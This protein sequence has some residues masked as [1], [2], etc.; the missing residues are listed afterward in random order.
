MAENPFD[1]R[2]AIE[3]VQALHKVSGLGCTVYMLRGS[4][5]V[6]VTYSEGACRSMCHRARDSETEFWC[7]SCQA[8]HNLAATLSNSFGGRYF[9]LCNEDRIFV[10]API[11]STEGLVAAVN[12]GPVHIFDI[13]E[14]VRHRGA[15]RPFPV[16]APAYVHYLSVLLS[17]AVVSVSEAS[18][19]ALL[20][21]QQ[22]EGTQQADIHRYI[23]MAR[24]RRDAEYPIEL[25]HNLIASI[26]RGDFTAARDELN[27]IIGFLLSSPLIGRGYTLHR[28]AYE[29][30]AVITRSGIEAGLESSVMFVTSE[31]YT[32][33]IAQAVGNARISKLL[34]D[35]LS[36]VVSMT[37]ELGSDSYD[38]ASFRAIE[39][40]R[41]H[42]ASKITLE[43]VARVVGFSP[44]YFSKNFKRRFGCTFSTYL[45]QVRVRAG[46]SL[47]LTTTSSIAAIAEAVGF[48]DASYFTRV[49]KKMTG[50]T[51]GYYRSHRGRVVRERER[52][53]SS[54][55]RSEG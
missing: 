29:L 45:N 10:A 33:K 34:L 37:S 12:L 25:E 1:E 18:Q 35:L 16:R 21:S 2:Q 14:N 49:F 48:D 47:L 6:E 44:S 15:L 30:C 36:E 39:Y 5:G 42:Y 11:V 9:Y 38:D 40:I 23:A 41:T 51:P 13:E 52:L 24:E 43:E 7:G 53:A 17:M 26:R 55:A 8:T 22:A 46:K 28:R 19:S 4:S 54:D 3:L 20:I 50:V 31:R 32:A 27:A